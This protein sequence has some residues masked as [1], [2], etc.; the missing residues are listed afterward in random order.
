M[1]RQQVVAQTISVDET[2]SSRW[3]TWEEWLLKLAEERTPTKLVPPS[4]CCKCSLFLK[5]ERGKLLLVVPV[6][7]IYGWRKPQTSTHSL[8]PAIPVPTETPTLRFCLFLS[9]FRSRSRFLILILILIFV[10]AFRWRSCIQLN[11]F[12]ALLISPQTI[13]LQAAID[14]GLSFSHST[15]LV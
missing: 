12:R 8:Q 5:I 3:Q 15:S 4:C 10:G 1:D 11:S 9:N 13:W 7:V 14:A 2:N 6:V